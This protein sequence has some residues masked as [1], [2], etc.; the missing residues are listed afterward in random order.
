MPQTQ[1][2]L[3][4]EQITALEK[5]A[6]Q[7]NVSFPDLLQEGIEYL[8]RYSVTHSEMDRKQ[9]ALAAAGRF[10]SGLHNLSREHDNYMSEG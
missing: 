6:K 5:L 7:R 9:R 10:H 2:Q 4:E 3:T 8:L 1:I